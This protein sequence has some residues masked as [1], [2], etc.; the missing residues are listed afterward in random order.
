M[1][2]DFIQAQDS[3]MYIVSKMLN[4]KIKFI[5]YTNQFILIFKINGNYLLN[6]KMFED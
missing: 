4:I 2:L 5:F 3:I 6:M 1:E